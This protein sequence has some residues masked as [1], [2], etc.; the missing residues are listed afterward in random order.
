MR[1][2]SLMTLCGA[3]L[4]CFASSAHGKVAATSIEELVAESGLIVVAKVRSVET[5]SGGKRAAR[6]Q[7]QEV[8][9]GPHHREVLFNASPTW[10]CD[11]SE[12]KVGEE[13]V[14]FLGVGKPGEL[15]YISHSGRG[16]MPL[17]EVS[18]KRYATLWVGDVI[19]PNEAATIPGPENE[20][21]FIRSIELDSLK[22]LVQR[23]VL[24]NGE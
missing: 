1:P 14:L 7:V 8:W 16:R 9:K 19:L 17:R 10:T 20:Y 2:S 22:S 12:A 11:I 15:V 4:L 5:V 23:L 13:A 3:G 21:S 24:T 18:G 6:A